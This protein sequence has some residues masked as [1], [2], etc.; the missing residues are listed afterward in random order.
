MRAGR[1]AILRRLE[2]RER[3]FG[4][5]RTAEARTGMQEFRSDAAVEP[6]AARDVLHIRAD[7]LAEV[8]HLVDEGDLGREE[9]VRRVFDQ[10]GAFRA[11]EHDRRLVQIERAI[12]L[13]HH[14]A[15][16][17]AVAADDDAVGPAEIADGRAFAQEFR[18]GGDVEFGIGPHARDDV[19]HL[20]AGADRHRRFGDHDGIAGRCR[21]SSSAAANT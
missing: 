9:R 1:A 14:I 7:L 17:V 3:V 5:T 8:R 6:D 13:A 20:A 4:K 2:Q 10:L 21:A 19:F 18:I 16:A 15:R 11:R 12:D